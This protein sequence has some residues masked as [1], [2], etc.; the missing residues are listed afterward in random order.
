[1]GNY[2]QRAEI[3]L[4]KY[5]VTEILNEE[6]GVEISRH[7]NLSNPL[8]IILTKDISDVVSQMPPNLQLEVLKRIEQQ[9][10]WWTLLKFDEFERNH[11]IVNIVMTGISQINLEAEVVS[12]RSTGMAPS[13]TNSWFIL[14]N[15]L[16]AVV[17]MEHKLE[18]NEHISMKNIYLNFDKSLTMLNPYLRDSHLKKALQ[19]II[20][21]VSLCQNWKHEYSYNYFARLQDLEKNREMKAIHFVHQNYITDML[22]NV[23]LAMLGL[24]T[25][26]SDTEFVLNP[27]RKTAKAQ[28]NTELI[29]QLFK[30]LDEAGY[31]PDMIDLLEYILNYEPKSAIELG[32]KIQEKQHTKMM[33]SFRESNFLCSD[34]ETAKRLLPNLRGQSP[35]DPK[36]YYQESTNTG[37]NW[38]PPIQTGTGQLLPSF[39]ILGPRSDM[40]FLS[41]PV[42]F[43]DQNLLSPPLFPPQAIR[44]IVET[45]TARIETNGARLTTNADPRQ[46]QA[47][48]QGENTGRP[49]AAAEKL[50]KLKDWMEGSQSTKP[51][52]PTA[53]EIRILKD[54][55]TGPDGRPNL[56][57]VELKDRPAKN[58]AFLKDYMTLNKQNINDTVP[59]KIIFDAIKGFT[60]AKTALPES[61]T[62]PTV[63]ETPINRL[64]FDS[65][66]LVHPPISRCRL[67]ATHTCRCRQVGNLGTQCTTNHVNYPLY[68]P[69]S[70]LYYMGKPILSHTS[71]VLHDYPLSST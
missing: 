64:E 20:K 7:Q 40:M 37:S 49:I 46:A 53:T 9:P 55:S 36:V 10:L 8:D 42:Q 1:M 71:H 33:Q 67:N 18:F 44:R 3:D 30:Q 65:A 68:S 26:R 66:P 47:G 28:L 45:D 12:L 51:R 11:Q 50:D 25:L 41:P 63:A 69:Y 23:A 32:A 21:P 61:T 70:H 6:S 39:P 52:E 16:L 4:N 24:L 5:T 14:T 15:L 38:R 60:E 22:K 43:G 31:D 58:I 17:D 56:N 62:R 48:Q 35:Y 19:D 27:E 54:F 57:G 2:I 34:P 29:Q 59:S 13:S